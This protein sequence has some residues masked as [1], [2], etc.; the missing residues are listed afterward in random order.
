M[1]SV[2]A[3]HH[4]GSLVILALLSACDSGP[5]AS[6]PPLEPPSEKREVALE[7]YCPRVGEKLP[8]E[9]SP[10]ALPPPGGR[11]CSYDPP[12]P[13]WKSGL[14]FVHRG[15][16]VAI[17]DAYIAAAKAAGWTKVKI[18][19]NTDPGSFKVL[20]H[21]ADGSHAIWFFISPFVEGNVVRV[22][23]VR[24]G[25]ADQKRLQKQSR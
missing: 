24:E 6:D 20:L 23:A 14:M 10:I 8:A 18:A 4:Q 13:E 25:W 1:L 22:G 5:P 7:S 19:E 9:W 11:L 15:E 3:M 12:E 16:V 2:A 17:R 21:Q